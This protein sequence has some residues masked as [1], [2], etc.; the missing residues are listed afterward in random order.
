MSEHTI[1]L[2]WKN[3]TQ[4]LDY[5]TY[6]RDHTWTFENGQVINASAAPAFFGNHDCVDPEQ[7][8]VAALSGCHML[9]FLA[10][11][12]KKKLVVLE[13]QDKAIGFLEKNEN[14]KLSINRAELHPRVVF[15]ENSPTLEQIK[16][17]HELAHQE[18]FI[19]QS[20][21]THVEIHVK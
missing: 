5:K 4:Q 7:A 13:Y 11:A 2:L 19:A 20:L 17:I 12:A 16:Q 15:L 1:S 14:G 9:T 3:K 18:C 10:I 6:S 21:R 8:L